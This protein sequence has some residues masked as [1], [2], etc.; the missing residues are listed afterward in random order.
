[1]APESIGFLGY[2][3]AS[4]LLVARPVLAGADHHTDADDEMA[5]LAAKSARLGPLAA[6][7]GR[8]MA[9]LQPVPV[10]GLAA[11]LAGH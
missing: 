7:R 8:P 1:M 10:T 9:V 5:R 2:K 3:L 4:K 6:R 11:A